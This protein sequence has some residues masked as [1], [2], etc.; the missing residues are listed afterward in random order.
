MRLNETKGVSTKVLILLLTLVLLIGCAAGGT[1]AWLMT[2][3]DPVV[4]TFTVGNVA[5]TL[6]EHVLNPTTGQWQQPEALTDVGNQGI[7]AL[8]GREILKDPTLTVLKGSE[9]CYVRVFIKINWEP[10]ADSKFAEFAYYDW[11]QFNTDWSIRRIF[12]G[13][14]TTNGHYVGY[15]VYELRYIPGTVDASTD[16]QTI[17]VIYK[18]TIP[19]YLE[20]DEISAMEGAGVTLIAQAV[21]AEGFADADAAFD[22]AGYPAGWDPTSMNP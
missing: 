13:T 3:T 9:K 22:A 12:D 10:A 5:I 17:P 20:K 7:Q 8:P 6:K 11:F 19:D 4:N 1:L 14:F 15:D 16:D 2:K 18:M 21:Q